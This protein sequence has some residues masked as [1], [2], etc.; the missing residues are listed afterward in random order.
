MSSNSSAEEDNIDKIALLPERKK[1]FKRVRINRSRLYEGQNFTLTKH[2]GMCTRRRALIFSSVSAIVLFSVVLVAVFARPSSSSED[3]YD[4]TDKRSPLE[5]EILEIDEQDEN[6]YTDEFGEPFS[7]QQIKLPSSIKPVHYHVHLR[8]N[9]TSFEFS[10][11]VKVLVK[12][13]QNTR[14]IHIH[15]RDL[16]I[17]GHHVY[18]VPTNNED[19]EELPKASNSGRKSSKLQMFAIILEEELK[20]GEYYIVY[21]EFTSSL[22]NGLSGFYKSSYKTKSNETRY[23]S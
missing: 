23:V 16:H 20:A 17:R 13:T 19:F 8:P 4:F 21:I 2:R 18:T 1:R 6:I 11:N 22:S 10:G 5:D 9:L 12:C 7:W 3:Q 14:T 15:S